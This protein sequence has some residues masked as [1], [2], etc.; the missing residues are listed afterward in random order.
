M[1]L[2]TNMFKE[3]KKG[4]YLV[5][6]AITLPILIIS[7]CS[8]ILIIKI[9]SLCEAVTFTTSINIIDTMFGYNIGFNEKTLCKD[10]KEKYPNISDFRIT[11]FRY[12]Y[13]EGEFSDLISLNAEVQYE[14]KSNI[15]I[16]GKINFT[17]K[18]LCR[19]FT[20]NTQERFPLDESFFLEY[21][22]SFDVYIFPKYGEKYHDD[23]CRYVTDS[24]IEKAYVIK[25]DREDALRKGY[26]PCIVCQGAVNG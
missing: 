13:D 24:K 26:T 20:G 5:E 15:G 12:L 9:I 2:M 16:E 23:K 1:S 25:M 3:N 11:R 17:E 6:A 19:G 7:I 4:S 18:I 21:R 10:I 14:V 8:L 22:D